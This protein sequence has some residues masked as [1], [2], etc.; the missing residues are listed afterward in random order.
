M[1]VTRQQFVAGLCGLAAGVPLGAVASGRYAGQ[2]TDART[3]PADA[4]VQA[5]AP[6]SPAATDSD[7]SFSQAGEDVL[8]NFIFRYMGL[9]AVTYL[10]VG[11]Y[12]PVRINNTYYFYRKGFRGVLVEPNVVMCR[13]LREVRPL[14][15]TLEAGIGLT[16]EAAA[17][18]YLMSDPAWNT[19]SKKEAELM[20]RNTKGT[21]KIEKVVQMPLY[22]INDVMHKYFDGRAPAYLSID[23]EGL[24]LAIL[25]KVDYTR[26]RPKVIC[27][28]TLVAGTNKD[29]PETTR[30]MKRVNY[31]ARGATFVNTIFVDGQLL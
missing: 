8:V 18:Y 25:K 17:D 10:D 29:I 6:A 30:F 20:V 12:D 27:V 5:A 31:V 13:R 14:D 26:F 15:T 11:A 28:E 7:M 24:H 4:P 9:G 3:T 19:F 2:K 16:N 21:I 23:A 22:D 1:K